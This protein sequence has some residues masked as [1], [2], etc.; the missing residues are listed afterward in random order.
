M[1]ARIQTLCLILLAFAATAICA[2][3]QN[4]A[5]ALPA[6]ASAAWVSNVLDGD[7]VQLA[8]GRRVRLLG[9]NTPEIQHTN[10]AAEAGGNAA[11]Q[12]LL[13][14]ILH[15]PVSL[16]SDV[17]A[18]DKYGRTLA[19]VFTQDNELINQQLLEQGL[20]TLNL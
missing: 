7:T 1:S 19:Y 13:Q 20:A 5:P 18:T 3:A 4:N 10:R 2:A 15:R 17:E 14:K 11:K 9:I 16:V 12:W 6:S 8:D